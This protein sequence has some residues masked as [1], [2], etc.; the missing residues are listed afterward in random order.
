MKRTRIRSAPFKARLPTAHN[1]KCFKCGA[2]IYPVMIQGKELRQC[3]Y[4]KLIRVKCPPGEILAPKFE[5]FKKRTEEGKLE[6]GMK[7]TFK[8]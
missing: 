7:E 3:S 2:V 4:C 6:A 5:V 1:E 8:S